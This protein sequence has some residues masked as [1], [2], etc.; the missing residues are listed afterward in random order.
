LARAFKARR[1]AAGITRVRSALCGGLHTRHRNELGLAMAI[2]HAGDRAHLRIAERTVSERTA[3]R[4]Q[5][6]QCARDA[7]L[8]AGGDEVVAAVCIQPVG[9][10]RHRLVAPGSL[11]IELRDQF[12]Q[13]VLGAVDV[14]AEREDFGTN[15]IV[16]HGRRTALY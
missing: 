5:L 4:G 2:G 3:H 1:I 15:G 14:G 10:A 13:T 12:Q 7:D 16:F 6:H 11:L 8:L 9:A